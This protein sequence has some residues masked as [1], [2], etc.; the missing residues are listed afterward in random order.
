MAD[1]DSLLLSNSEETFYMGFLHGINW[2]QNRVEFG[3]T[4]PSSFFQAFCYFAYK[5]FLHHRTVEL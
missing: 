5:D 3:C 2:E 4:G 1:S